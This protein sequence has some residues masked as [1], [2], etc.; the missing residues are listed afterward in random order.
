[1]LSTNFRDHLAWIAL[2]KV[3]PQKQH[4]VESAL[5]KC[6]SDA[7]DWEESPISAFIGPYC[8]L[9]QYDVLFVLCT[10]D[11]TRADR[12]FYSAIDTINSLG[13]GRCITDY[14]K[15]VGYEWQIGPSPN[16][17]MSCIAYTSIKYCYPSIG[18]TKTSALEKAFLGNIERQLGPE[19]IIRPFGS[20]SSSELFIFFYSPNRSSNFEKIVRLCGKIESDELVSNAVTS[21]VLDRAGTQ[22]GKWELN[23]TTG[24]WLATQL[25]PKALIDDVSLKNL[26]Y[27][28]SLT[29]RAVLF[30]A[31]NHSIIS[32]PI[33]DIKDLQHYL[34][35]LWALP[36]LISTNS[37]IHLRKSIDGSRKRTEGPKLARE[38]SVA[39]N[40]DLSNV[41]EIARRDLEALDK[42]TLPVR[43]I[44]TLRT[45]IK[46]LLSIP[47]LSWIVP[48]NIQNTIDLLMRE[49]SRL[50]D[51][52]IQ[53]YISEFSSAMTERLAGLQLDTIV[54]KD[55]GFLER[56]GGHQRLILAC[57]SLFLRLYE[58][59]AKKRLRY[60]AHQ[61]PKITLFV[62]F[63]Y[64]ARMFPEI[65]PEIATL[66]ML[67]KDLPVIIR[68]KMLRYKPW[69]WANGIRE[70]AKLLYGLTKL[71]PT[72][73]LLPGSK[74]VQDFCDDFLLEFFSFAN[75]TKMVAE[76]IGY[77]A[78]RGMD[79][80][81]VFPAKY[82]D[83]QERLQSVAQRKGYIRDE[84]LDEKTL[85]EMETSL[86]SGKIEWNLN[87]S[88]FVNF[89]NAFQRLDR[90][91][92][93]SPNPFLSYTISLFWAHP[94]I[95][96]V[97]HDTLEN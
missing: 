79:R 48:R 68:L 41:G 52:T 33:E 46:M 28:H 80:Y 35:N 17:E 39:E 83:L 70:L 91:T 95:K 20:F 82:Q 6:L 54:G 31:Q 8:V 77:F 86:I 44:R 38:H 88:R 53:C 59:Y 4:L 63:D 97:L 66:G 85:E 96:E 10:L 65:P 5:Q 32:V 60:D 67:E 3:A 9:G 71:D 21:V 84:M 89:V 81:R 40:L 27:H 73:F 57:E 90:K 42:S 23:L 19:I 16:H 72:P 51:E 87:D 49:Q 47:E 7:L 37:T 12:F 22:S 11:L 75:V 34:Y 1:M 2:L 14:Y 74:K 76:E 43:H 62:F 61:V 18:S 50:S 58:I 93:A 64:G 55:I 69:L 13:Q 29:K 45:Q 92:Q 30:S 56:H 15:F 94:V 78:R 25:V 24:Y 36:G 26:L